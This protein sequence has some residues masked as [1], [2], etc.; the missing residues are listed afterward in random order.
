M[1]QFLNATETGFFYAFEY[2]DD[3]PPQGVYVTGLGLTYDA[4]GVISGGV[5]TQIQSATWSSINGEIIWQY[6]TYV[7]VNL[8]VAELNAFDATWYDTSNFTNLSG[9]NETIQLVTSGSFFGSDTADIV[10]STGFVFYGYGGNDVL[11]GGAGQQLGYGGVGDDRM[12]GG[13]GDDMLYGE[14]DNDY[15]N[16]GN[17][18]D[19]LR[20]GDGNDEILGGKGAD[21]IQG[22]DGDDNIRAG[23]GDDSVT[24]GDGNDVIRGQGGNDVLFG[25]W[26]FGEDTGDDLIY[27]GSGDDEIQGGGGNDR[28]YGGNDNDLIQGGAGDDRMSGGNGDDVI[29]GFDGNDRMWGGAGNDRLVSGVGD[30]RMNGGSGD[31]LLQAAVGRDILSGGTGADVFEFTSEYLEGPTDML[32]RDFNLAEDR[33]GILMGADFTAQEQYDQFM[34]YATQVG[35]HVVFDVSAEA[36]TDFTIELRNVE[37]ELLTVDNFIDTEGFEAFTF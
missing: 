17:G 14:A 7:D 4:S 16:G 27:G 35:N 31:D 15:L 24:G 28:L 22:N 12:L 19:T 18:S 13:E 34:A 1:Y 29:I 36:G 9:I 6:Q 11:T 2:P 25:D 10:D 3:R 20:G 30:Q 23:S 26:S 5:I 33:L 8:T 37:L 32:V 21:F